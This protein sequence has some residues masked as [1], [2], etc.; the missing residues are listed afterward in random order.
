M[1][2]HFKYLKI[3]FL[4][5]GLASLVLIIL[6]FIF[7]YYYL[8]DFTGPVDRYSINSESHLAKTNRFVISERKEIINER[9]SIAYSLNVVFILSLCCFCICLLDLDAGEV[10]DC[11]SKFSE[12][13]DK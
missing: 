9:P 6:V 8:D 11:V 2:N 13:I 10:T 12:V 1:F 7:N 3:F 5:V 4:I